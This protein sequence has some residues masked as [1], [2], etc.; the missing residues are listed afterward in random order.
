MKP[1]FRQQGRQ[2]PCAVSDSYPSLITNHVPRV[3]QKIIPE[4][5]AQSNT[6]DLQDRFARAGGLF[7]FKERS[8]AL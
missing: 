7:C 3:F 8:D 4:N 6:D 1:D 5:A 2:F